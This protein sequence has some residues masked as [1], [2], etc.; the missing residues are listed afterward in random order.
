MTLISDIAAPRTLLRLDTLRR[1]PFALRSGLV[2]LTAEVVIAVLANWLYPGDPFDLA[3]APFLAPGDDPQ[4]PL[5]TDILG[6]DIAAGLVHG[7]FP[8]RRWR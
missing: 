2:I 8:P 4:F 1:L 3:G 6:R 7:A 5:G